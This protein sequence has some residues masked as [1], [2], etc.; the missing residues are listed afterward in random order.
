LTPPEY[1]LGDLIIAEALG[2]TP[3]PGQI[4]NGWSPH[5]DLEGIVQ[6]IA[7]VEEKSPQVWLPL[8]EEQENCW[9]ELE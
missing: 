5:E 8:P 2:L 3:P 7:G 4:Q 9:K 6:V 1:G